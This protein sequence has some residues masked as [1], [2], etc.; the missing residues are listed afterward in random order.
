[1]G[2]PRLPRE[3]P[4][5]GT[6]W[7]CRLC[8]AEKPVEQFVKKATSRCGYL[9]VCKACHSRREGQRKKSPEYLEKRRLRQRAYYRKPGVK[10]RVLAKSKARR[11]KDHLKYKFNVTEDVEQLRLHQH[12]RCAICLSPFTSTPHLDHDHSTG[13][14]RGLLCSACN[15]GLGKFKDDPCLLDRAII[16]LQKPPLE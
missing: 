6:L 11:R 5:P 16:Y 7:T 2:R 10:D 9:S 8:N 1:M 4:P 3:V 12:N 14:I 13:A 15:L